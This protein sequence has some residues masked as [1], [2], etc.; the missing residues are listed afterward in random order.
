MAFQRDNHY[1]ARLYLKRFAVSPGAVW[2]YRILVAHSRVPV[3]KEKAIKGVAYQ[4]HLYTRMALGVESDEIQKWLNAE[5]ETPAEDALRKA[6]AD[7]RLSPT[8]SV[9]GMR[10]NH[11]GLEPDAPS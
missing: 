9:S 10:L 2:T 1:V 5:F 8:K 4:R 3:W 11:I 6:T 7:M